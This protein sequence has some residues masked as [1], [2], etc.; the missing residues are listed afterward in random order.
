M[1][2]NKRPDAPVSDRELRERLI[3]DARSGWRLFIESYTPFLVA[4]IERAGIREHDEAMDVYVRVCDHLAEDD[5]A[6]LRRHDPSKGTIAGWLTVVV[7]NAVVDWARSRKGRPRLFQSIQALGAL[8]RHVFELYYWR[9]HSM[10]EIAGLLSARDPAVG[11]VDVFEALDRI[12]H[13]LSDR[14]RAE[15]LTA[16]ARARDPVNLED[17]R[18]DLTVDVADTRN[19]E[20]DLRAAEAQAALAEA[21]ASLPPEDAL[22]VQ[23]RYVDGLSQK[24]VERALHLPSLRSERVQAIL[25]KLR[26][27]MNSRGVNDPSLA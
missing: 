11:L 21:L 19:A 14:Q 17:E 16:A 10:A 5:C 2:T 15:L 26:A 20:S 24:Q 25:A 1:I 9:G 8:D 4:T 18:G 6:R 27:R 3:A 13:A 7:R 22:I 23:M 12:E